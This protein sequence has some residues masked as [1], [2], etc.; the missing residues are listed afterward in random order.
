MRGS[1]YACL[2]SLIGSLTASG[3]RR[4]AGASGAP[5][6][7]GE[8]P[9]GPGEVGQRGWLDPLAV[10]GVLHARIERVVCRIIWLS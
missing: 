5:G 3:V 7:C 8:G 9:V 10:D 2:G 1:G 4:P 6:C